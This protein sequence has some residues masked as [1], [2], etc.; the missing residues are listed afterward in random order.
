M[1]QAGARS[2]GPSSCRS[3]RVRERDL[4]G[5]PRPGDAYWNEQTLADVALRYPGMDMAPY[6]PTAP[7]SR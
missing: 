6:R 5:F 3:A 7:P 4:F 2:G 1:A